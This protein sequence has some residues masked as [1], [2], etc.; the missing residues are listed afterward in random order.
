MS[1]NTVPFV[2]QGCGKVKYVS[3]RLAKKRKYCTLTCF[4]EHHDYSGENNPMTG[5]GYLVAGKKNGMHGKKHTKET[6]EKN[7]QASLGTNNPRFIDGKIKRGDRWYIWIDT[8]RVRYSRYITSQYLGR[9][10]TSDEI[11]HHINKDPSD[12]RPEN[13]YLFPTK[14]KHIGFHNYTHPPTLISNII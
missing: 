7:R 12:D 8:K 5:R 11:V 14:G 9:K 10:L 6:K 13:L 1:K 3:P 2:C 4:Y